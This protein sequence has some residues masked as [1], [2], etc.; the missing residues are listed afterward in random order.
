MLGA[1]SSDDPIFLVSMCGTPEE[2]LAAFRRYVDRHGLFVPTS[3]PAPALHHGRF[4]ITLKDGS[5]MVEGEAEIASS[6]TRPSALYG[7]TGMTLHF[8]SVDEPSRAALNALEKAKLSIKVTS[9]AAALQARPSRL[10]A[11]IEHPP[12][13]VAGGS[14][15]KT[16]VLAECVL[17]GDAASLTPGRANKNSKPGAKFTIP[18]IQ[19]TGSSPSM[20]GKQAAAISATPTVAGPPVV[21][22]STRSAALDDGPS[23][24]TEVGPIV[25]EA[26]IL[27][28]GPT[29]TTSVPPDLGASAP[30][31]PE[32]LAAA[33]M[34]GHR[35]AALDEEL[36]TT[37]GGPP[38]MPPSVPSPIGRQ[39]SAPLSS[40]VAAAASA[41]A[42]AP[43]AAPIA[44]AS[45]PA[46]API[47]APINT[48]AAP[49]VAPAMPV[50][51]VMPMSRT[52][53]GPAG[54]ADAPAR[55]VTAPIAGLVPGRSPMP[56][57]IP[58]S[59]PSSLP[60]I[61]PLRA[62]SPVI[63]MQSGP[64][65]RPS[66]QAVPTIGPAKRPSSQVLP[67]SLGM[68]PPI[69]PANGANSGPIA[70][71]TMHPS[72]SAL[73]APMAQAS[74]ATSG[75]TARPSSHA[76]RNGAPQ[77]AAAAGHSG[78]VM[79][80]STPTIAPMAAVPS[81][82]QP[83]PAPRMTPPVP[84]APLVPPVAARPST[85]AAPNGDSKTAS[86]LRRTAIGIAATYV[87][88]APAAAPAFDSAAPVAPLSADDSTGV[89]EAVHDSMF[90][91]PDRDPEPEA[92][93]RPSDLQATRKEGLPR[94]SV[95]QPSG[96][97]PALR[98]SLDTSFDDSDRAAN[99]VQERLD[100]LI[101]AASGRIA[102]PSAISPSGPIKGRATTAQMP[103]V[104]TRP[105]A[106]AGR[107]GRSS[108]SVATARESDSSKNAAP[109]VV[110]TPPSQ[111][112]VPIRP[113]SAAP[114]SGPVATAPSGPASLLAAQQAAPASVDDAWATVP[115]SAPEHMLAELPRNAPLPVPSAPPPGAASPAPAARSIHDSETESIDTD[116]PDD[117]VF[118]AAIS[119]PAPRPTFHFSDSG[120]VSEPLGAAAPARPPLPFVE[121]HAAVAA[122]AAAAEAAVDVLLDDDPV[123]DAADLVASPPAP[124][125]APTARP[126]SEPKS[127]PAK[128]R[129]D[130]QIN[131]PA[132]DKVEIDPALYAESAIAQ[133]F[134][135][136]FVL[137]GS[138]APPP[139]WQPPP[140]DPASAGIATAPPPEMQQAYGGAGYAAPAQESEYPPGYDMAY[141]QSY[142]TGD[143]TALVMAPHVGRSR[144]TVI[145]G[146]AIFVLLAGLAAYFFLDRAKKQES[147]TPPAAQSSNAGELGDANAAAP[148]PD[149]AATEPTEPEE[150][151]GAVA[152]KTDAKANKTDAKADAKTDEKTAAAAKVDDKTDAKASSKGDKGDKPEV[153]AAA[154]PEMI[155]VD[156]T[157]PAGT[158]LKVNGETLPRGT[159]RVSL[160]A[161][162]P[163]ELEITTKSG[164]SSNKKFT[165][166]KSAKKVTL[167]LP[168]NKAK[169]AKKTQPGGSSLNDL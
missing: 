140:W 136:N 52:P 157:S 132:I 112:T 59:I 164:R 58:S 78:A 125:A 124:E 36:E 130:S 161:G 43:V 114:G 115:T 10:A 25:E 87:E 123:P 83:S 18:T 62:P 162:V 169:P 79:R 84:A 85:P 158:Q 155:D 100:G 77:A 16:L 137:P 95:R 33:V 111:P 98:S 74:S 91:I 151:T 50:M 163:A 108:E 152:A 118:G 109:Q 128:R 19:P 127:A 55:A 61:S 146:S 110:P 101:E 2:F 145:V 8:T 168:K 144:T 12:V 65:K 90:E 166:S 93:P 102:M 71:P 69:A 3:T 38:P 165:P 13:K 121:P 4:A 11:P 21:T 39:P 138:E 22:T 133:S 105:S 141:P 51:P 57:S 48:P 153:K 104:P 56:A 73:G 34:S 35:P 53:L 40:T 159:K 160:P 28:S 143:E 99:A 7:R 126:E 68:A 134:E 135:A 72:S 63:D 64:V 82:S 148:P 89:P 149:A 54:R 29:L 42:S 17:V 106:P 96:Q 113:P 9:H 70:A 76:L 24:A 142:H 86:G 37:L 32:A 129:P 120:S 66:S 67:T 122:E 156:I 45:A 23:E 27:P 88:P 97:S 150:K 139:A 41:P 75:P 167:T 147:T 92:V 154:K 46:S 60:S 107:F 1:V 49:P 30:M 80:P 131:N 119:P 116:D 81:S 5:V 94:S 31:P 44:A 6:S 47:A 117:P 14:V 20:S 26:M 103:P 15:D